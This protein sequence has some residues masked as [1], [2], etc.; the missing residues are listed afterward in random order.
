MLK[1]LLRRSTHGQ[2]DVDGRG[3]DQLSSHIKDI[4]GVDENLREDASLRW[5]G[6][7]GSLLRRDS[8]GGETAQFPIR[9]IGS[10]GRTSA[11]QPWRAGARKKT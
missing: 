11:A 5:P 10:V 7:V 4:A 2:C 8:W 1:V 6:S 9:K 3:Q